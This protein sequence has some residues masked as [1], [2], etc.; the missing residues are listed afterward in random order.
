MWQISSLSCVHAVACIFKLNKMVEPYVPECF[1]I[2]MFKQAYT[3]FLKP[4]EGI[5]FWPDCS[6]L[7]RIL[8]PLPKKMSGDNKKGCKNDSIPKTPKVKWKVGRPKK[9]IPTK[10][11]NVVDDEDLP[12][13]NVR[14]NWNTNKRGG[15]SGGTCFVK[16]RGGTNSRGELVPTKR[17]GRIGGW[18]GLD[19]ATSD[20]IDPTE[21]R[22]PFY[23]SQVATNF[24]RL[25]VG[26]QQ[27]QIDSVQARLKSNTGTSHDP[28][29]T[30]GVKLTRGKHSRSKFIGSTSSSWHVARQTMTEPAAQE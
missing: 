11:T 7:S 20:P 9:A 26:T 1:K 12:R 28:K 30:L 15:K 18:L 2:E 19:A 8:G 27:S 24:N 17:L 6:R 22:Q 25:D 3:Q 14:R 29:K 13:I 21:D 10:N 16:M 5:T 23:R 4:V